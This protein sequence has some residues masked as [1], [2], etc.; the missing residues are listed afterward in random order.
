MLFSRFIY[1]FK[2]EGRNVHADNNTS[3]FETQEI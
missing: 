3:T 1:L 2:H